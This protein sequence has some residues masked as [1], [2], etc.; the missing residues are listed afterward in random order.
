MKTS[1]PHRGTTS[2]TMLSQSSGIGLM[3]ILLT[4]LVELS[5]SQSTFTFI[6]RELFGTTTSTDSRF[7]S[8][9]ISSAVGQNVLQSNNQVVQ[10]LASVSR[11]TDGN[12]LRCLSYD[13]NL[14][15]VFD[16][17]NLGLAYGLA[18]KKNGR[19][20][21]A[22]ATSKLVEYQLAQSGATY[23]LTKIYD[24]LTYRSEEHT[25]GA[26]DRPNTV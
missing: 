20:V 3:C 5:Q 17:N 1:D 19:I 9:A 2:R 22:G 8:G 11:P 16:E 4:H 24:S 7:W 6:T 21:L 26:V 25:S 23:A 14:L 10:C 18:V 13:S 12:Q 15:A